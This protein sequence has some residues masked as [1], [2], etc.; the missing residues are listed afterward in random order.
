MN[1]QRAVSVRA[2]RNAHQGS[3]ALHL[4]DSALPAGYGGRFPESPGSGFPSDKYSVWYMHISKGAALQS[5]FDDKQKFPSF[6]LPP[7]GKL[8]RN[9]YPFLLFEDSNESLRIAGIGA[10]W[11]GAVVQLYNEQ[12]F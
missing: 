5:Y 11:M 2:N 9:A 4:F 12:F 8:V 6:A 3:V 7:D 1:A 10:E